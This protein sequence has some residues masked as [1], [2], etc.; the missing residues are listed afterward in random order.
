M[1]MNSVDTGQQHIM[2]SIKPS[3]DCYGVTELIIAICC[4]FC[5]PIVLVRSIIFKRMS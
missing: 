4:E 1:V 3:E 5:L 2:E